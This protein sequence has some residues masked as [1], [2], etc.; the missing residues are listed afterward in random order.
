MTEVV[1]NYVHKIQGLDKCLPICA[2]LTRRRGAR[3]ITIIDLEDAAENKP[4]RSFEPL[5][6]ACSDATI[7][8][9]GVSFRARRLLGRVSDIV[10]GR[11]SSQP[12]ALNRSIDRICRSFGNE[13]P[14][15]IL[16]SIFN[17]VNR[18]IGAQ[19]SDWVAAQGG[20]RLGYLKSLH[21]QGRG[22]SD[23][24]AHLASTS[25][26][27]IGPKL[28]ALLVP[29][30]SGFRGLME[31]LG[32]SEQEQVV[33]G[34]PVCYQHWKQM[35]RNL[36]MCRDY[37]EKRRQL[38]VVL[39][40]R[41][42]VAHKAPADQII[43]DQWLLS[44]I[45]EIREELGATGK[46]FRLR[47]KPHPYQNIRRL[48]GMIGTAPEICLTDWPPAMLAATSDMGIATYSSAILDAV[49]MGVPAIEYFSEND[50]FK[51][52]HPGGS[53]FGS[54]GV[55]ITRTRCEL[56]AAISSILE[57]DD[58]RFDLGDALGSVLDERA[59]DDI[60]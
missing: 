34:Y 50:A 7:A 21:D 4:C 9:Q 42:E 8:P 25:R 46:D 52:L 51:R 14:R 38:E 6:G 47:I 33:S 29:D 10:A 27:R 48:R 44:A 1:L 18:S 19:L 17:G 53:P 31:R 36:P 23:I 28:D 60:A 12:D 35:V 16:L 58:M 37:N 11:H 43:S 26:I 55:R 20:I 40:T 39:F 57:G 15:F 45:V 30:H 59:L 5:V 24:D 22:L 41:G 56:A 49:A 3:V 13:R 2:E 32:V 54:L